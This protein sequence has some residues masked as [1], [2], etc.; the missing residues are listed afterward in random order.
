[1]FA[2]AY[3]L[4]VVHTV[5]KL[6]EVSLCKS[7][8]LLSFFTLL[9]IRFILKESKKLEVAEISFLDIAFSLA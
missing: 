6:V 9:L 7:I 3:Q 4:I 8:R 1:M 2:S 5:F